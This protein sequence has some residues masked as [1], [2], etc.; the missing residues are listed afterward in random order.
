MK[1]YIFIDDSAYIHRYYFASKKIQSKYNGENIEVGALYGLLYYTNKLKES[2]PTAEIIHVLDPKN[3]SQYR[4]SI[5][6]EY[7]NR[8]EKEKDLAD[9]INLLPL[10]LDG[11]NQRWLQID[12]VESDDILGKYSKVLGRDNFVMLGAEDK[13]IL[14]HID[15][16]ITEDKQGV[17]F[18]CRYSKNSQ[19]FNGFDFLFSDFV[20]EKYGVQPYQMGDF[21]AIVGDGADNIKGIKGLGE[22][23]ARKLLNAYGNTTNIL[24][25][26]KAGDIKGR[27]GKLI[28]EGE[29]DLILS[30]KLTLPFY[31]FTL[32]DI[33][34][35]Q[36]S[37][38]YG[39][40]ITARNIVRPDVNWI[41]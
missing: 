7:K 17:T 8:K 37:N 3:G 40:Q 10:I 32:P 27:Q 19:G 38:N 9:Q 35:V 34:Q 20:V 2:Y 41:L 1:K 28:I 6:P 31:D 11:Y 26:A 30:K 13:D 15:D 16:T 29:E 14:Q 39:N 33:D 18:V 36:P 25:A 22:S 24:E 23:A 4:K 5:F 21:L 12:G